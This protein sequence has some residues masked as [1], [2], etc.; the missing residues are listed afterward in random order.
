MVGLSRAGRISLGSRGQAAIHLARLGLEAGSVQL[1]Y[2]YLGIYYAFYTPHLDTRRP[3][4]SGVLRAGSVHMG[5]EHS[6][7][8]HWDF[9][10]G[11]VQRIYAYPGIYY[12]F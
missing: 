6:T 5:R 4:S 1:S 7:G 3:W 12:A 8:L 9:R 10:A 2:P 11:C